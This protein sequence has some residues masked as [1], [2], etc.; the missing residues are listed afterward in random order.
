MTRAAVS[1][2]RLTVAQVA[3]R[4]LTEA[5]FLGQVIELAHLLGWRVAHFRPAWTGR[6]WRTPVQ[7][8]GAGFPDLLLVRRDRLIA[9]ELK[10]EVGGVVSEDQR[11]WLRDMDAAGLE[12]AIWRPSDF[13]AI[14]EALR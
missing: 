4:A 2:A 5:D 8:D 10:R 11:R 6:G 9:A 7:G 14:T 1:R 12:T 13:A 3:D